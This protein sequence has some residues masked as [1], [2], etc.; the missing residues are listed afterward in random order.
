MDVPDAEARVLVALLASRARLHHDVALAEAAARLALRLAAAEQ[1]ACRTACR[2][3]S[4]EWGT[5]GSLAEFF[6]RSRRTI[7]RWRRAGRLD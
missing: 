6:G 7:Q 3:P 2:T 1:E 5:T 4:V